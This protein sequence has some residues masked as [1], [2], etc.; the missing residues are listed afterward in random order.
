MRHPERRMSISSRTW[1][2]ERGVP[3]S[4]LPKTLS[5]TKNPRIENPKPNPTAEAWAQ[6]VA[7]IEARKQQQ[8][9]VQQASRWVLEV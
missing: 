3:S 7:D 2:L 9:A 5:P 6:V 4:A 1:L 8:K